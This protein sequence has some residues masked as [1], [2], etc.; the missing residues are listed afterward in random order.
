MALAGV[1][2]FPPRR[3]RRDGGRYIRVNSVGTPLKAFKPSSPVYVYT[4][5]RVCVYCIRSI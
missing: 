2:N 3:R 1:T 4:C 5:I